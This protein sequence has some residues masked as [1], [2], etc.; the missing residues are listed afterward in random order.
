MPFI[1]AQAVDRPRVSGLI[2]GGD[3]RQLSTGTFKKA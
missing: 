1:A 2:R 3:E